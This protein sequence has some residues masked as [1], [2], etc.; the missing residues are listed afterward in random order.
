MRSG[1]S[2]LRQGL[3]VLS[4]IHDGSIENCTNLMANDTNG[5]LC[6]SNM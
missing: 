1:F 6:V 2:V 5:G 4:S 3:F